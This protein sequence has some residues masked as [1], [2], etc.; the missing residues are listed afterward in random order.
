MSPRYRKK[1]ADVDQSDDVTPELTGSDAPPD[2]A[3]FGSAGNG[4]DPFDADLAGTTRRSRSI[5][6]EGDGEDIVPDRIDSY[7]DASED[8][9]EHEI[10]AQPAERP[11]DAAN[12]VP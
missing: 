1:P 9:E 5:D 6:D 2:E 3:E 10:T 7:R 12:A 8:D 11:E 4:A